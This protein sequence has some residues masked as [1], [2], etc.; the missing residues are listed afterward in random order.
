MSETN[1]IETLLNEEN[2]GL[3]DRNNSVKHYYALD[4]TNTD[5]YAESDIKKK[6]K[7]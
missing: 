4:S 6:I 1:D 2:K 3:L 7:V 5:F